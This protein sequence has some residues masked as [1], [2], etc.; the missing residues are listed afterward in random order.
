MRNRKPNFNVIRFANTA[1]LLFLYLSNIYCQ[2]NTLDSLQKVLLTQQE[3]TNKVNTLNRISY[4]Y[5]IKKDFSNGLE[6]AHNALTLAEKLKFFRGQFKS[7]IRLSEL[8]GWKENHKEVTKYLSLG[9]ELS[10]KLN[11]MPNKSYFNYELGAE[12]ILIGN[13]D[14]GFKYLYAALKIYETLGNKRSVAECYNVIA[15]ACYIRKDYNNALTNYKHSLKFI[16]ENSLKWQIAHSNMNIGSV[17]S[18]IDSLELASSY[19]LKGKE[20]SKEKDSNLP[21]WWNAYSSNIFGK[22]YMKYGEAFDS[23]KNTYEA[24]RYYKEAQIIMLRL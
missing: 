22:L 4:Q 23:K 7:Y 20:I 1:F 24:N 8:Y 19:I 10:E 16:E 9:L 21:T 5:L 12:Y 11:D 13:D 2:N 14:L 17:Y 3:D 15:T 18:E 6:F